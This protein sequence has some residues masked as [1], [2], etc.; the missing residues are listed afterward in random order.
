MSIDYRHDFS[1]F[2]APSRADLLAAALGRCKRGV[3][4]TL[5]LVD[6]ALIAKRICQLRERCANDFVLTPLLKAAV[7]FKSGSL[8]ECRPE[9]GYHCGQYRGN[10]TNLMH[11]VAIVESGKK[12]YLVAMMS[13]VLK[14]NSAV[15]HQTIAGEIERLIQSA[16]GP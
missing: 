3:D 4:I 7:Y 1:A 9:P 10:L 8:F 5:G 14:V 6:P 15:E 16:P 2:S 13:N 12:I 11:S